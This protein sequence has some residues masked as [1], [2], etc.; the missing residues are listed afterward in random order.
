M[1]DATESPPPKRRGR[2]LLVAL[3]LALVAAGG[4]FYATWSG[5]VAL[6][7]GHDAP[8]VADVPPVSGVAFVPVAPI[9]VNIGDAAAGRHLRFAAQLEVAQGEA[10]AVEALMPR[11]VDVLNGYLRAVEVEELLAPAAL[12]R[13]RAQMLR[14]VQVVAGAGRVR[15]LLVNEF[16]VN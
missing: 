3:P 2:A 12:V 5:L 1:S 10:G 15:D 16:V 7:A 8:A 13:L 14:R 4:G 9:L 6:P 11:I